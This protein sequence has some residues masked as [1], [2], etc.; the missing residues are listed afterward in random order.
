MFGF[1]R[2]FFLLMLL[3]MVGLSTYLS[4]MNA[5]D[6]REPLW[7]E[8]YPINGDGLDSTARYIEM[9]ETADF[10][11]IETF[12]EKEAG[13]YRVKVARPIK[14]ILGPVI[15]EHP[16]LPP[17]AGNFAQIGLWSLSLRWWSGRITSEH[18]EPA[19]DVKLFL[20]YHDPEQTPSLNH[21]V[22]LQKGRVGI[23]NVFASHLQASVNNFVIAHE[24]LHT[25]GAT[26]KYAI[27]SL[28]PIYPDGY[29]EPDKMPLYPQ[30]RAEIMGGRI[31]LSATS[32][33]M[34]DGLVQAS[35]GAETASEIRWIR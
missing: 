33:S 32:V 23:V 2:K 18:E 19:P 3:F 12:M 24:M 17:V 8:V 9:L 30:S 26:D 7:V 27:P 1:F 15:A 31:A 22:G 4:A 5:T 6:W 29:D 20:I 21:S 16:P 11:S 34:P 28:M 14:M 10:A 13:R 25:L 35:V